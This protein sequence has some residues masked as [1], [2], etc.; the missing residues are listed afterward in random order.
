M[1]NIAAIGV[2]AS[3]IQLHA[4][5]PGDAAWSKAAQQLKAGEDVRAT[6]DGG[7]SMR[8]WFR[9]VS[10]QTITLEI[11]GRDEQLARARI[12]KL[13]IATGTRQRRHE[14]IGMAIGAVVG[15]VLWQRH[16]G[17]RANACQEEAMLYFGGPML[18]GGALGHL[19]PPG[20]AWREIYARPGP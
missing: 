16:C 10:E 2:L 7:V 3:A 8:G 9:E 20:T 1:K 5:A 15:T 6:L 13:S 12:R 17:N 4:P 11:A 18:G 14:Y 19:L